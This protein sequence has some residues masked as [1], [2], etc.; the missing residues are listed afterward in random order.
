[1]QATIKK[2]MFLTLGEN[3]SDVEVLVT[4]ECIYERDRIR[5]CY[6]DSTPEY[7]SYDLLSVVVV[8]PG[9]SEFAMYE[10]IE[11]DDANY[12]LVKDR[13]WEEFMENYS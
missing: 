7:G 6:A 8:D 11:L 4:A 10:A 13:V 12:E 3:D 5:Q 9:D 2:E 1:M